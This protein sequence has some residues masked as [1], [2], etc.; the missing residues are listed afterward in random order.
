MVCRVTILFFLQ[1]HN[2]FCIVP[3]ILTWRRLNSLIP[4]LFKK[5]KRGLVSCKSM[6]RWSSSDS[7]SGFF[8]AY[9]KGFPH[10][11]LGARQSKAQ[12]SW[13]LSSHFAYQVPGRVSCSSLSSSI[14]YGGLNQKGSLNFLIGNAF[15]RKR[16]FQE[17]DPSRT[18]MLVWII[19]LTIGTFLFIFFL[20][21]ET[22][23]NWGRNTTKREDLKLTLFVFYL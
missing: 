22:Q 7:T 2:L 21:W 11:L 23:K 17:G 4:C 3:K 10:V 8:V 18:K 5:G 12:V 15:V 1:F 6:V 14:I 13:K 16:R 19:V 9:K 20:R